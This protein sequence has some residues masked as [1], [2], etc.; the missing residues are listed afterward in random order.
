M[1]GLKFAHK[2]ANIESVKAGEFLRKVQKLAKARNLSCAWD[3]AHGK[4]SHGMLT[5]GGGWTTL[6]T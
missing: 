2:C 5:L 4:G 6:K 3:A 1:R